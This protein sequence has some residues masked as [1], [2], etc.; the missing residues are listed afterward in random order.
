LKTEIFYSAYFEKNALVYFKA[1]VV[2]V[3]SDV[4]GLAPALLHVNHFRFGSQ[5]D[6]IGRIFAY[7]VIVSFKQFFQS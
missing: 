4:V 6:E 1:S 7:W 5:G 3:I 2:V